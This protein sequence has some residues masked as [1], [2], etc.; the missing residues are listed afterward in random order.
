MARETLSWED[1]KGSGESTERRPGPPAKAA[2]SQPDAWA[3][4]VNKLLDRLPDL[5]KALTEFLHE[6]PGVVD[7]VRRD[8]AAARNGAGQV[9][10]ADSRDAPKRP[11]PAQD[12]PGGQGE[13][14]AGAGTPGPKAATSEAL[15]EGIVAWVEANRTT[16]EGFAGNMTM[17]Q[18]LTKMCENRESLKGLLNE[19]IV[20][21][22]QAGNGGKVG[23]SS[24]AARDR[25]KRPRKA[26]P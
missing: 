22:A 2:I 6:F 14:T 25:K 7:A 24:G 23:G 4:V 1:L 11:E 18:V 19:V 15:A 9:L 5:T 13:P 3:G 26:G 20:N 21:A 12:S 8:K 17:Q 16:I 10:D